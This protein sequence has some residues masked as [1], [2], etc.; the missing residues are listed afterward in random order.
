MAIICP[1]SFCKRIRLAPTTAS[2]KFRKTFK[3]AFS[4]SLF[5]QAIRVVAILPSAKLPEAVLSK[6]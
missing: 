6:K 3:K 4:V 1:A 5:G 2:S